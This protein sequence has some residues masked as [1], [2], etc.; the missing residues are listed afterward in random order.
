[1]GKT[2]ILDG[3][4]PK[5]LKF[6]NLPAEAVT[7]AVGGMRNCWYILFFEVMARLS[8]LQVVCYASLS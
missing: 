3:R 5:K 4:N 7:R 2:S 6:N 8:Q 1:M